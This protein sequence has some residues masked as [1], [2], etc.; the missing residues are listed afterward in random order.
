ME[1]EVELEELELE[2]AAVD[3]AKAWES[4]SPTRGA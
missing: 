3:G 2:D 4:V 1:E